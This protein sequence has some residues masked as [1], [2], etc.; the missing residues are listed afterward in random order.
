MRSIAPLL[1]AC[2]L[3]SAC[4]SGD[5]AQVDAA[6]ADSGPVD[7]ERIDTFLVRV[8]TLWGDV[9]IPDAAPPD[10]AIDAAPETDAGRMVARAILGPPG[11]GFTMLEPGLTVFDVITIDR[12]EMRIGSVTVYARF[13]IG[14]PGCRPVTTPRGQD[15]CGAEILTP[16]IVTDERGHGWLV[17][18]VFDI[19]TTYEFSLAVYIPNV[20]RDSI[21][22][23]VTDDVPLP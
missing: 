14:T 7:A 18:R 22:I 13:D 20:S 23:R 6:F 17:L 5:S 11:E 3:S 19:N 4:D 2:S 16:Q 10:V 8:D 12:E 9:R 21:I 1:L 15:V